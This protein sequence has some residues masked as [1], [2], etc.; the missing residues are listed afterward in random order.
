MKDERMKEEFRGYTA[1]FALSPRPKIPELVEGPGSA[2]FL[3][4]RCRPRP[5][6]LDRQGGDPVHVILATEPESMID[7]AAMAKR[8]R[9]M[10]RHCALRL[11][12]VQAA[13]ESAMTPS[14]AW[15]DNSS[16]IVIPAPVPGSPYTALIA[17]TKQTP[18]QV[19]GDS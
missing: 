17:D 10:L 18:E 1:P 13:Q 3:Q 15:H 4:H 16:D 2:F 11:N 12:S 5:V 7:C 8:W 14:F 6:I 9:I 19:R